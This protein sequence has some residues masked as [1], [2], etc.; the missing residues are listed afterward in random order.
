MYIIETFKHIN[1]KQR[2]FFIG[3][4]KINSHTI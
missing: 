1:G 2:H 3:M 4:Q